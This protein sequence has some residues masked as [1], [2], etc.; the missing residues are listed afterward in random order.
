MKLLELGYVLV[1]AEHGSTNTLDHFR[2]SLL[3]MFN[4]KL[5]TINQY[6]RLN[7]KLQTTIEVITDNPLICED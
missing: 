2:Y 5:L 1:T 7:E 4:Y 3:G 6:Q